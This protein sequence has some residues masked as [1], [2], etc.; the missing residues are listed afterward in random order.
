MLSTASFQHPFYLYFGHFWSLCVEEQFYLVWPLLVFFIRDRIRLR[1]FCLT[2]CVLCLAARILCVF[3]LPARYL[4]ADILYR[5]TPLRAD[6]LLLGGAFALMLRGPEADK[7]KALVRPAFPFFLLGFA[8]FEGLYR[9]AAHHF[10][11]PTV[12][13]PVLDTIGYSLLDLFAAIVIVL[14]LN[15]AGLFYRIFTI[16][17]LRRLGQVSYGFY[18]FHDI[19]HQMYIALVVTAPSV[20]TPPTSPRGQPSRS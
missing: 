9:H 5:L 1:N 2:V 20:A 6:A 17:P 3:L 12:G 19:P 7:L 8:L 11:Y 16:K 18:V 4:D 13:A 10:Y 15:P 14:S